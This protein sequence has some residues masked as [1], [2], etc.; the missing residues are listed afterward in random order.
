MQIVKAMEHDLIDRDDE[1][2]KTQNDT[3]TVDDAVPR[4]YFLPQG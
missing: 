4:H 1:K 2:T 3:T